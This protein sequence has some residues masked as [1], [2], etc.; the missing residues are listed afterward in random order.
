MLH[1]VASPD[2][3]DALFRDVFRVL[4]P[5]GFFVGYDSTDSLRFRINHLFDTGVPVEPDCLSVR[6]QQA[7][8]G[9]IDVEETRGAF[10]FAARRPRV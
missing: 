6:L 3:Q 5:G 10:R 1:H 9:Q 2:L 4:K 8:F 7:G